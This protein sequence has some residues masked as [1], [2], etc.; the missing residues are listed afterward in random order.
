MQPAP[1]ASAW[2]KRILITG[3]AL[4]LIGL[5]TL[6]MTL[7]SIGDYYDPRETSEHSVEFGE[8]TGPIELS[9][10]CWVVNVEDSAKDYTITYQI[11]ENGEVAGDVDEGCR[12]D[13]QAQTADVDFV[14]VTELDI[15]EKSQV[16]VKITCE[17]DD[18]CEN[19]VLF[20]N[21]DSVINSMMVDPVSYTHLTL[22]TKA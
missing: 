11:I 16:L 13:F 3:I 22:P 17:S 4:T 19:P 21:G 6:T 15:D 18:G 7:G 12:T 10:G 9:S 1:A 5:T 8:T 20:T 14:T 2:P